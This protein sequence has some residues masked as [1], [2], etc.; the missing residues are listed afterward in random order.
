MLTILTFLAAL[1]CSLV[2]VQLS[3]TQ[4]SRV[5]FWHGF[6]FA[7]LI[8]PVVGLFTPYFSRGVNKPTT[9]LTSHA[10]DFVNAKS[11]AGKKRL[12]VG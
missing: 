10:N 8:G 9:G 12:L 4:R 1:L 2:D 11:H 6:A 3:F 5:S 7:W